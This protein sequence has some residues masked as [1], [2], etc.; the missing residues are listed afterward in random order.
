MRNY[1]TFLESKIQDHWNTQ[2]ISFNPQN[3]L[4]IVTALADHV[5]VPG[6][7]NV[8]TISRDRFPLFLKIFLYKFYT[9]L[10]PNLF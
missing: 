4:R 10:K 2:R 5:T 6:S 3:R 7:N 1:R 8:G 9:N